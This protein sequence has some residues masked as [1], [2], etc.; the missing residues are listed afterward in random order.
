MWRRL[1]QWPG[2][3][4]ALVFAWKLAL[5]VSTAQPIP[6]ND[7]FFY[8]GVA[9]N[10]LL[11]GKY[12][13]PSLELTLPISGG[14]VFSAYPP[15]YQLVLIGWMKIFGTSAPAAMWLH[16]A[17]Y[18]T[19]MLTL[20]A[21]LRRFNAPVWCIHLAGLFLLGHTFH[22]RP[23]SLAHTLG[24]VAIFFRFAGNPCTPAP[25]SE[26][27]T[28]WLPAIL[29]LLAFAAGPV[30][31]AMYLFIIFGLICFQF[32]STRKFS[33]LLPAI[34]M[35]VVPPLMIASVMAYRPEWWA[36]F[37][38]HARQTPSLSAL[39]LP[40]PDNVLKI[41]RTA[42]GIF[43]VILLVL[44]LWPKLK[45]AAM[46]SPRNIVSVVTMTVIAAGGVIFGCLFFLT[47][48]L[49]HAV[50]YLQPLIVAGSLAILSP[51]LILPLRRNLLAG[52]F[53]ALALLTSIRAIGLSTW[54]VACARDVNYRQAT[55]IVSNEL[56]GVTQGR[57]TIVS[58]AFLYEAWR[59]KNV[60]LI[61][62]DWLFPMEPG[63]TNSYPNALVQLKPEK[64]ILTQMDYY[65][66]YDAILQELE[67]HPALASVSVTNMAKVRA[68]DSYPRIQRVVQH[69]SWAPV[70][71]T[72]SWKS[73]TPP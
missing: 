33:E 63:T 27:L 36:G 24:M 48:N 31:G 16:Y 47:A 44:F 56:A 57:P 12:T 35:M 45:S 49:I 54:G 37:M 19:Y 60:R 52:L 64:L 6:A 55:T 22:D 9:V 67:S 39:H 15:L 61:H 10:Y 2:L 53:V 3:I 43:A 42:P 14:K 25:A 70:V 59:Q 62:S 69:V 30:L 32:A 5:L 1:A 65:R 58:A 29:A 21:T 71:V 8:D 40:R 7:S 18:V 51:T 38:E 72:L 13:N 34:A 46:N 68:P 23:D 73:T 4:F 17:L 26:K 50:G 20:F 66:R 41:I 11:N 28:L